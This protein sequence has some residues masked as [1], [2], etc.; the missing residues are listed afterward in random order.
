[1]KKILLLV[2][3]ACAASTNINAQL[4]YNK[5]D[6][7]YLSLATNA[8][9]DKEK[10]SMYVTNN[11][12]ADT[13]FEWRILDY[14]IPQDW[15]SNGVCDWTLCQPFADPSWHTAICKGNQTDT[16]YMEVGRN[17][18]TSDGC[19]MAK[20]EFREKGQTTT[21][22]TTL[23]VTSYSTVAPCWPLRVGQYSAEQLISIYPNPADDKLHFEVRNED[24]KS[25][26]IR[27][28]YGQVV[29]KMN[30]SNSLTEL[31]ITDFSSGLYLIEMNGANGVVLG[32]AKFF[33]K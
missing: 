28:V 30:L 13:V 25:I 23:I 11:G 8:N 27:T 32:T 22:I 12:S 20:I 17:P 15:S 16:L 33:K 14:S 18:N 24:I 29:K 10:A 31:S 26:Q 6:T 7:A 2:L 21:S 9:G 4:S 19:A 5:A 3:V 1:M